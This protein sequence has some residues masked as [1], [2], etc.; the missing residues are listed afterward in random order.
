MKLNHI[1]PVA[2]F[3][4]TL[5]F[6]GIQANA[7]HPIWLTRDGEPRATITIPSEATATE[8]FAA[9]ELQKYIE[10]ISGA[11]L[12]V[13]IETVVG[14]VPRIF[15]GNTRYSQAP[16]ELEGMDEDAFIIKRDWQDLVISG[17]TDRATLYAVYD[18]LENELGCRWL[19]PGPLWE[20]IP[21]TP[22]IKLGAVDRIEQPGLK[23]RLMREISGLQDA[24]GSER[25]AAASWAVKHKINVS[26][27]D[28]WWQQEGESAE[29]AIAR[30]EALL[31]GANLRRLP[32][33]ER[34][35][36]RQ[37]LDPLTPRGE[38][39]GL[40][41][42]PYRAWN[43]IH[44]SGVYM[45]PAVEYFDEHPEWYA[46]MPDGYRYEY[47]NT[48][49]SRTHL[50]LTQ[51]EVRD[52]VAREIIEMFDRRP[53]KEAVTLGADGGDYFC[54]CE[55]CLAL[56]SGR[57]WHRDGMEHT[58]GW[59]AF[60][61]AVA[62]RV[63]E[64][65][66]DKQI[67][68]MGYRTATAPPR[69]GESEPP[70]PNVVVSLATWSPI[71]CRMHRFTDENCHIHERFLDVYEQWRAVTPGGM[72]VYEYIPRG[73][74]HRM[75]YGAARIFA[76]DIRYLYERDLVGYEGQTDLR[77]WG[78]YG[79]IK[80]VVSKAMWDP[81]IDVDSVI[82]DYTDHAF[83]VASAPMREFYDA[84]AAGLAAGDC[85]MGSIYDALGPE[86]LTAARRHL[87]AA[88]ALANEAGDPQV[89]G[90]LH[91]MEVEFRFTELAIAARDMQAKALAD[92]D[93]A[94]LAQA[95]KIGQQAVDFVHDA[96]EEESHQA[97][98]P[99]SFQ[100]QVDGWRRQLER[101]AAK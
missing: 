35:R 23:Y 16:R 58:A 7:A 32:N 55:N 43:Q 28:R 31:D 63:A 91:T 97:L 6:A 61:N 64:V 76:D 19:G 99:S 53:Y 10:L 48:G 78:T 46:K 2:L 40:A 82:Q 44:S 92:S 77:M 52:I 67:I 100:R 87:D 26:R 93:A 24:K 33:A 15:I 14:R 21:H 56:Y 59:I 29:S 65:Y 86:V 84:L 72:M 54:Q 83:G 39:S 101:M 17:A 96:D 74:M 36:W 38:E 57:R 42:V 27:A 8:R 18:F 62:E 70:H 50:C 85:N 37:W 3:F 81:Y 34:G 12:P 98:T 49:R 94:L 45:L 73:S 88:H 60:V 68:T 41:R 90:R 4:L 47:Q 5:A 79:L 9:E 13:Q 25:E 89:F 30:A 11:R 51:P 69:P 95:I 80:Y 71:G 75:P 66:P 20:Y 22:T 1:F